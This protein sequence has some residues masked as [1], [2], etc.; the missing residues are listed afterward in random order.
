MNA[1]EIAWRNVRRNGRRSLFTLLALALGTLA[2]LMFG[3]YVNDT[4]TGL[5]TATVRTYGHLQI[6]PKDYLDFG[7]GNPGRFSIAG[8]AA[9]VQRIRNDEQLAPMLAL[10][11]PVLEI[12]GVAGNFAAGVS[13]NFVGEGVVPE[14]RRRQLAWDGFG[15]GIPPGRTALNAGDADGG[16]V[17][18][19]MAQLLNLC[20]ALRLSNCRRIEPA[21]VPPADAAATLP[22]D[23]AALAR[24]TQTAN[25]GA[26]AQERASEVPVELLAASPGGMP[27]VV[28]MNVLEAERQGIRQID[29]MYVAL[30]LPL[31]QRLVFGGERQAVSSIVVQVRHTEQMPAARARLEQIVRGAAQ[32][33]EVLSFHDVSPAYDQ[34]VATYSTIFQFIAWLMAAI[35]L[36]S[37]SNAVTM[38]VG[39]RTA[40]IG[41]LRSLGFQRS[42]IRRI[43]VSE[44]ALLGIVGTVVGV[45]AAFVLAE[46]VINLA[47]L[48]WTPPGRSSAIPI[49]VDIVSTPALVLLTVLGLSLVACLSALWPAHKAARL[50]ITDALRRA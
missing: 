1:I 23:T 45:L 12:E 26:Q 28:R 18:L 11:T 9:L 4:V 38:A 15:I 49:R 42:A 21:A 14:E 8:Y 22:A 48:S 13:S 6:V 41:T 50:E 44:G 27:N 39:E 46:G 19:R 2:I 25:G 34:I 17:G 35:T 31:A 24:S 30:P 36:F 5:Q 3:G 40:E 20:D 32:P 47:G 7:R 16:V 43:F 33:L 37:I 29:S 10:V